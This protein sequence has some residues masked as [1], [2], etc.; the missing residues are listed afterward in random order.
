MRLRPSFAFTFACLGLAS[1]A[2]PADDREA[3]PEAAR[4]LPLV[5][6]A[7][8]EDGKTEGWAFTDQGAWRIAE[9]E[10]GKVL[11]QFRASVYE[12]KVRSP[13]NIALMPGVDV[14]DFVLDLKVRST[15]RD[16]GHRDL[17]LIFG[18]Q[19][20]SHFYYAHLGKEADPHAHSIFLVKD[21]PRVSIAEER[22]KG[23]PWTDGWHR[24]RVVRRVADGLVQVYFDDMTKP[25]MVAHDRAFAHGR[26]GV[27]SFDDTGQFDEIRLWGRAATEGASGGR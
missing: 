1:V 7:D 24:V 3:K 27:G 22:T 11:E 17:C 14:A 21:Q 23:T 9:A 4:D 26:V 6:R 2:A 8:F 12:P 5:F 20:G 16:Y 13:F 15:A 18:H 25:V 19:D 10:G